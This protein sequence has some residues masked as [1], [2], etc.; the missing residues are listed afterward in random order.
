MHNLLI[1]AIQL[2]GLMSTPATAIDAACTQTTNLSIYR[3]P[4]NSVDW[5]DSYTG[6]VDNL[7]AM[8]R[9]HTSTLTVVGNAFSV[10]TSTLAVS[11]GR[12]GVGTTSPAT[13]IHLSSG[14]FTTDGSGSGINNYGAYQASGT[15][16]LASV[17]CPAGQYLDA[18]AVRSG[19][20]TSGSCTA[21]GAGIGDA[22]LSGTQTFSGGNTFTSNVTFSSAPVFNTNDGGSNTQGALYRNLLPFAAACVNVSGGVPSLAEPIVNISSVTDAGAG[23]YILN[24]DRD[25]AS[26]DY[27]ANCSCTFNGATPLA[28]S[29]KARAVTGYELACVDFGGSLTDSNGAC[30]EFFGGL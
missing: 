3:C 9:T 1:A 18:S 27:I 30:C 28:S 29:T 21:V 10:G 17:T 6:I 22:V 23:D 5:Y 25:P 12:V 11:G 13:K 15:S 4:D 20:I 2:L 14:F 7:D 24:F 8:H 26:A 19:L 16:G